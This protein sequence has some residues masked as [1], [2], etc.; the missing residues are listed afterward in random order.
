MGVNY[1]IE[2]STKAGPT[3]IFHP[4]VLPKVFIT[5]Q[6]VYQPRHVQVFLLQILL[7]TF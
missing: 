1:P 6:A 2:D 7:H 3:K 5:R 4:E